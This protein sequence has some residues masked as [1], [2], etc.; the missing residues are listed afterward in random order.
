[1]RRMVRPLKSRSTGSRIATFCPR[2]SSIQYLGPFG[3]TATRT[4][5][6]RDRLGVEPLRHRSWG[7][8]AEHPGPVDLGPR[9]ALAGE[10]GQHLAVADAPHVR[11]R[12][13][14]WLRYVTPT[15]LCH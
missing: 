15:I 5:V 11:D 12:S 13:L 9:T 3:F 7:S 4:Q 1:M 6:L 2:P 14:R 10:D 8:V